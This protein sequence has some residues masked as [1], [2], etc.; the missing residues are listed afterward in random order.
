MTEGSEPDHIAIIMDGNGRW[1]RRRFSPRTEGHKAGVRA[2]QA[3]IE[4][5]ARRGV[6]ALTLF[7]FS[8]E[9]WRRPESE[10]RIL[11]ELFLR[12]LRDEIGRLHENGIRVRFIGDRAGLG[13]SLQTEIGRA[14]EKTAANGNL[15]VNIAANYGGRQD[16]AQAARRVAEEVAAGRMRPEEVDAR[17]LGAYV[18]LSD[19]PE[20]DLFI[21]TGGERRISNYLLWHLAY[22]ELWFTDRL[23]PDFDSAALEE[24]IA[25][26]QGRQRR[27]GR[28]TEQ[29]EHQR[30]A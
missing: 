11:M 30:H 24:A 25:D 27:F 1:A 4:A 16:I 15:T 5:C 12:T 10:V 22:T 13:R 18:S 26:Y 7:A 9:N 8:S 29:V 3:I 23:W 17:T 19:L 20:P 28:T 21:R 6:T 2:T 14:E